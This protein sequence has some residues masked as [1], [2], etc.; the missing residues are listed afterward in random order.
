M[1]EARKPV[2]HLRLE[3]NPA[4]KKNSQQVTY[5]GI[6]SF[7]LRRR[8]TV[9]GPL[10]PVKGLKDFL[11][12]L[13]SLVRRS[14]TREVLNL[15]E[16]AAAIVHPRPMPSTD[17]R[18]WSAAARDKWNPLPFP[19][20]VV[21]RGHLVTLNCLFYLG[22]R[23]RPDLGSL[24]Q[25]VCDV[26]Q[27]VG[28]FDNDYTV[29]DFGRSRRIWPPPGGSKAK[30]AAREAHVPRTEVWIYDDGPKPDVLRRRGDWNF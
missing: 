12:S 23:Q 7:R 26:L 10:L 8:K 21:P 28:V 19:R 11:L 13:H 3:G 22:P 1:T 25:A 6:S 15:L 24:L 30:D 16:R 9:G 4:G 5:T 17:F 14:Q 20:P 2:L 27:D 18:E 29:D